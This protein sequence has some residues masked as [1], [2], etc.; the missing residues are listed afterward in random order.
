[1]KKIKK[2]LILFLAI[3]TV[4]SVL[5]SCAEKA[6]QES[7][8]NTPN[9]GVI[10]EKTPDESE[11]DEPE[12]GDNLPDNL[13][14]GGMEFRILHRNGNNGYYGDGDVFEIEVFAEAEN[15][16]TINDAIYRRN[17]LVEERLNIKIKPIG[18]IDASW[19]HAYDFFN[20]I[21]KSVSAG[22]DEF[23][24]ALGYAALMPN[25]AMQGLFLNV[26]DFTYID[27]EKPWWS[28]NFKDEMSI[29]GKSYLLEGDYS[30]SLLARAMCIF[31]NKD[32]ARDLGLENL[33]Q[34][35]LGGDWTLDKIS[36]ISKSAYIDLNGDGIKDSGD[37]F[38]TTI[39]IG[40]YI[41]NLW[42]AFD[43]PVTVMDSDGYPVLAANTSKMA[44]MV[45]KTYD[46]LYNNEGVN[47]L[48]ENLE[49]ELNCLNNFSAGNILFWP[50]TLYKNVMLRATETD[51]GILPYPK[52]NKDQ[53]RYMTGAQDN[54]SIIAIPITCPNK[55][56][57]GA[58]LEALA[59]E[60]YRSVTP[61]YYEIALKTKYLR[62]DES[63]MMLD[64]IRDGISFNF[65]AYHT[66]SIGDLRLQYR[67]LMSDKKSDWVSTYEK[68][69]SQYQKGLEKTIN[70]YMNLEQ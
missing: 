60:S 39:T 64:I 66:D 22:D 35:V 40:T 5:F 25:Y 47:A 30:L 33:Y 32:Y 14:F 69:E 23:D 41:D 43:Q 56:L 45:T 58:A 42:F 57:V 52:W 12:I 63:A 59:A 4:C 44:E 34:T 29:G 68:K 15:G 24:V 54:F 18:I 8:N 2:L 49:E 19:D 3:I 10:P 61:A 51:Y 46:F 7:V 20:Y 50:N 62:D 28:R 53:K 16:D 38:G 48:V 13:D 67:F 37:R 11:I 55:E 1:M 17:K 65:G 21:K 36:E 27:Y 26:N 6:P 70:N 9:D 31:Y